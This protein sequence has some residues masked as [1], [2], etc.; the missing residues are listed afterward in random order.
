MLINDDMLVYKY[1]ESWAR[2]NVCMDPDAH[3]NAFVHLWKY[4]K[5]AKL[6]D[7]QYRPLLNKI[8]TS[9]HLFDWGK[10]ESPNCFICDNQTE[11]VIH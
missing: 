9:K 3:V 1:L 7:F 11:T 10:V 6:L 8:V 4:M 5:I 2:D